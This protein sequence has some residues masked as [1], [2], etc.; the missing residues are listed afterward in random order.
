MNEAEKII[1]A[2]PERMQH[3]LSSVYR[4]NSAFIKSK[5]QEELLKKILFAMSIIDRRF[6]SHEDSYIDTALPIGEGQTISQPSTVARMLMLA[7]LE[8]GDNVLEVGT[9]SGWNACLISWLVCPGGVLSI[10]RINALV[11]KARSNFSELKNYLKVEKPHELGKLKLKFS[12]GDIFNFKGKYDKISITAGISSKKIEK[13]I[14]KLA[15]NL[16]K[17][18]G[19]LVCPYVSGPIVTF[20]KGKT[21]KRYETKEGYVFV[22]LLEGVR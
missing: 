3:M 4:F 2:A 6:F 8:E 16:L 19:L 20:K 21:L 22:P 14:E 11:E 10:D 15:E 17:Q 9:G 18:N 7:E 13:K 5:W 1:K 12:V